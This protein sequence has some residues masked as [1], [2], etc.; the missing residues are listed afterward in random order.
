MNLVLF[1]N[2]KQNSEFIGDF[3]DKLSKSINNSRDDES[4]LEKIQ[5]NRPISIV[6]KNKILSEKDKILM[7]YASKTK[8]EGIMYFIENKQ[9]TKENM[10]SI[11]KIENGKESMVRLSI[12]ELPEEARINSV[13]REKSGKLVLDKELT[14]KIEDD[15][16][17]MAN[18]VLN[19][20][21][22]KIA[23][24]RVEGHLYV[25][26]EEINDRR[27]IMDISNYSGHDF[28]EVNFPKSLLY[29]AKVGNVFKYNNGTYN[30]Y[31]DDG[32]DRI[33]KIVK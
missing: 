12:R 22:E 26:T 32:Y 24:N 9:I 17:N 11:T 19:K 13:L 3:I 20:Q 29:K 27:F 10:Y 14:K 25:I 8:Q 4:I 28:E 5:K 21:D 7:E 33:E 18:E 1:N 30:Y 31:S 16:Y 15:I 2:D 23:K 6:S